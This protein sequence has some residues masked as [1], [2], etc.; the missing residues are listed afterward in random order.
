MTPVEVRVHAPGRPREVLTVQAYGENA[1]A[2]ARAV[3]RFF[4]DVRGEA[5]SADASR[6]SDGWSVRI[7]PAKEYD[8]HGG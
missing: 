7:T 1:R 5:V 6:L 2:V 3:R 4:R 8:T